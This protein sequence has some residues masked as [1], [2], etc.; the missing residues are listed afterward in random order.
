MAAGHASAAPLSA[1]SDYGEHGS[2]CGYCGSKRGTSVSHGM[3]ADRLS[4]EVYQA[5]LDR[6]VPA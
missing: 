6:C 1:I 5:L 4:V 2:S 3:M